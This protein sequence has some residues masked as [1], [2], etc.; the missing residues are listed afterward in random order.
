MVLGFLCL[1]AGRGRE[2]RKGDFGVAQGQLDGL[3]G[4]FFGRLT[5]HLFRLPQM[6]G[7]F[8]PAMK[9]RFEQAEMD[10]APGVFDVVGARIGGRAPRLR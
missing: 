2:A 3:P 6:R 9:L 10:H 8:F 1:S 4:A 7:G 5:E